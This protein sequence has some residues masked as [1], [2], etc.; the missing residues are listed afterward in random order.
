M[1][2]ELQHLFNDSCVLSVGSSTPVKLNLKVCSAGYQFSR[3]ASRLAPFHPA[4]A[5]NVQLAASRSSLPTIM[6][7][8]DRFKV[9]ITENSDGYRKYG[10]DKSAEGGD[11]VT[12]R[13]LSNSQDVSAMETGLFIT[14]ALNYRRGGSIEQEGSTRCPFCEPFAM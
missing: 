3:F 12:D 8:S 5:P 1:L 10:G 6:P 2:K 11:G 9:S 7:M 13:L 4:G 14:F